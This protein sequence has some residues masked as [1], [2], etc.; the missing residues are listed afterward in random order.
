MNNVTDE[1]KARLDIAEVLGGYI[2]LRKAGRNFKALCPFHNE[3]TP[4]FVVFPDSQTWRCFGACGEGGDIFSFVMKKE[5]FDFPET[6]R[7]L[8]ERAGVE[9]EPVTPQVAASKETVERLRQLLSDAAH[10]FHKQLLESHNGEHARMYVEKRGLRP[11]TIDRFQIGFAPDGW[12]TTLLYLNRQGYEREEM[13]GAG[14]LVVKDDGSTYD[15]F[16]DRLI[17]PIRDARGQMTGFGARGLAKDAVP[18]YLNSPQ[19]ELFDKSSL[20]FGLDMAR[21]TIRE[22]ETAVIVEGYMDV[23]QAHQAGYTNVVA[24]MGTA[25]TEVQLRLLGRYAS[26]L[27]LALDPDTA[28]QM[29][30]ER[31]REVIERV[32]KAAAEQATE[33]G[34]WNFDA[35]E[36]DYRARLTA[37]FDVHGMVRYESRLGFDIRV[38]ALP[39][40]QDPDDVIRDK[41]ELW[42]ELVNSAVP[43]IEHVIRSTTA[44]RDLNDPKVKSQI[45]KHITPLIEEVADPV[46]RSHYRQRLARLLK[47]EERALFPDSPAHN[48]GRNS[49]SIWAS[50][51][52][53]DQ[54]QPEAASGS[55]MHLVESF[56]MASLI[57]FPPMMYQ[58]N[59]VLGECLD[60]EDITRTRPSLREML[61]P[62]IDLVQPFMLA[63]DFA[64]PEY[65][66]IFEVWC[67]ALEQDDQEPISYLGDMLDERLY[68]TVSEWLSKP[69]DALSRGVIPPRK[70][71]SD[72]TVITEA[73]QRMLALRHTRIA[74]YI[75]ELTYIMQDSANSGDSL[76]AK[77]YAVTIQVLSAALHRISQAQRANSF[78][79]RPGSKQQ[80]PHTGARQGGWQ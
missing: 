39:E 24:Q 66:M 59:R 45:A 44:D 29:A 10:F 12:D 47:V 80:S 78:T 75:Q 48:T 23:I 79:R 72:D 56:C 1:I 70:P 6:L 69:L 57:V 60:R 33:E 38:L 28:G 18:K 4:S 32:S 15:R 16:R 31:G 27:I 20:L 25:L 58:V 19:S 11:D 71:V 52:P 3:K 51:V 37:E 35:A 17:I 74:A 63:N 30:T 22:S 7:L 73:I 26:R 13:I 68:V 2:P 9:L 64:H 42:P 14:M 49:R 21:R 41:P 53:L 5:G 61:W 62:S 50:P 77:E 34:V 40:G 46:E 55:S 36:R 8:A 76:T 67:A 54:I 43:I 65:R